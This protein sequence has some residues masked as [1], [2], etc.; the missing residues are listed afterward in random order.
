[1]SNNVIL[2]SEVKLKAYTS[3]NKNVDVD[4]LKAEIKVAQDIRLQPLLGTKFYESL[5]SKVNPGGTSSFTPDEKELVDDYIVPFLVHSAYSEA[6]PMIWAR[7]LNRG[8][9]T[10]NAESSS[11]VDKNTMT[12]LKN[13]ATQRAD[14][15]AERMRDFLITGKGQ[16]KFQDYITQTSQDGM[17]PNKRNRTS[18]I[19]FDKTTRKG[20]GKRTL[21][22]QSYSENEAMFGDCS[23]CY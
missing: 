2:V 15:Y 6:L 13:I 4:I 5:L 14:F 19:Y 23:D 11:S 8:V 3:I 9:M 17:L 12:Y 1:M 20:W 7:T 16:N 21:G 18:A 22:L 10:G